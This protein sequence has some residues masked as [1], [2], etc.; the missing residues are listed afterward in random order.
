MNGKNGARPRGLRP[1]FKSGVRTREVGKE[2]S[3]EKE[4]SISH[5]EWSGQNIVLYE[6]ELGMI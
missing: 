4:V 5:W 2:K 1:Y 6:S 3:T